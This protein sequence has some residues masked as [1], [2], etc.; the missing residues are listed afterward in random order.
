M[1]LGHSQVTEGEPLLV[2]LMMDPARSM[3]R[4]AIS[5]W[6][7][8]GIYSSAAAQLAVAELHNNGMLD[9]VMGALMQMGPEGMRELIAILEHRNHDARELAAIALGAMGPEVAET[10]APALCA[11]L[12]GDDI[13]Q[14]FEYMRALCRMQA[15]TDEVF[16]TLRHVSEHGRTD[17]L[18]EAAKEALVILFGQDWQNWEPAEVAENE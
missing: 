5:A 11:R 10:A 18:R 3:K 14:H 1:L 16:D 13:R 2:R 12:R 9:E 4:Q 8:M 15:D 17:P 7:H 6:G